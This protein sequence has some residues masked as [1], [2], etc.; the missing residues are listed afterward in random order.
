MLMI[1]LRCHFASNVTYEAS[2][3]KMHLCNFLMMYK[4]EQLK[5]QVNYQNFLSKTI[6]NNKNFNFIS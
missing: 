3:T 5:E 4:D 2:K 1:Y 6:I